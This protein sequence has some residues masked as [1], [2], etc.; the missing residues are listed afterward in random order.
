[1]RIY[2]SKLYFYQIRKKKT[3]L[4]CCSLPQNAMA[5]YADLKMNIFCSVLIQ[6]WFWVEWRK[7]LQDWN[8]ANVDIW[9]CLLAFWE[10]KPPGKVVSPSRSLQ[11]TMCGCM[12]TIV[13]VFWE[14]KPITI[15]ISAVDNVW[16]QV[17]NLLHQLQVSRLACLQQL[18]FWM[19][20]IYMFFSNSKNEML[21]MPYS[22]KTN[23]IFKWWKCHNLCDFSG[24]FSYFGNVHLIKS[25]SGEL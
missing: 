10:I 9:I 22:E 12:L 14:I 1:M 11:L 18:I 6:L 19:N 24:K 4:P 5:Y 16:M 7:N 15:K 20:T 25:G 8:M 13:N 2:R 17:D 23:N 3:T 21:K